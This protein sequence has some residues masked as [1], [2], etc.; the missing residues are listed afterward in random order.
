MQQYYYKVVRSGNFYAFPKQTTVTI[1]KFL[2]QFFTTTDC[3]VAKVIPNE[4]ISKCDNEWCVSSFIINEIM[5]VE[6]LTPLLIMLGASDIG[7]MGSFLATKKQSS[8]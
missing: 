4:I 8:L 6:E 2:P 7:K 1:V 5:S 3:C